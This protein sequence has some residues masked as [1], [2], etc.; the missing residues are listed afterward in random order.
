LPPGGHAAPATAAPPRRLL[1]PEIE[2][3]ASGMM[4]TDGPHQIAW[5]ECGVPHGQ[6]AVVLHGGP[7]GAV[8]PT[9]RRFF[10][11]HRWRVLLFDQRG[12]GKSRPNGLLEGNDTWALVEDIERLRVQAGGRALDGVRRQ[13]GLHPGLGVRRPAPRAGRRPDPARRISDHRA[14]GRLVLREGGAA[15]IY[16]DAWE[17]FLAPIPPSERG[18]LLAAYHRRLTHADRAVRIAAAQAWSRWEGDTMSIKGPAAR[19]KS[20]TRTSSLW[21]SHASSATTSSTA[22]SCLRTGGC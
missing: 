19:P 12:C 11:P 8:N 3:Y 14:R 2:P 6:P 17:Q 22:A 20:S 1:Y 13:L 21:P 4:F 7:G 5:E 9:M 16:P 18:D 15:M 10:D